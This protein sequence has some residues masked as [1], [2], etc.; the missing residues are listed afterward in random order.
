[1]GKQSPE[2]LGNILGDCVPRQMNFLCVIWVYRK[3]MAGLSNCDQA[4]AIAAS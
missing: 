4:C 1:M 2:I 3:V